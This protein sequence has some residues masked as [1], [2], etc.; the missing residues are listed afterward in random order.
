MAKKYT[1]SPINTAQIQLPMDLNVL[2]EEMSKNVHE[3]W[4]KSRME[5]G[6]KYGKLRNDILKEHP[7]LISY[8]ELPKEEKDLDRNTAI[9]TL[10]FILKLGFKI[11]K[12]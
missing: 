3:V 1:P 4:A 9:E 6:W 10:K 12:E 2:V 11:V 8:E 7:C 5:Q